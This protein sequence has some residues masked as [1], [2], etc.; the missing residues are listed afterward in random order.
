VADPEHPFPVP[1]A[2]AGRCP[3]VPPAPG[4]T[5]VSSLFA[6]EG[7]AG[8]D[9]AFAA[10][11]FVEFDWDGSA[12]GGLQT[13]GGFG[14][15]Q[16]VRSFATAP[17]TSCATATRTPTSAVF[18]GALAG[19]QFQLGLQAP[20]PLVRGVP[21]AD[22]TVVGAMAGDG[23]LS[24]RYQGDAFPSAGLR[25]LRDGVPQAT[26]TA[27]D[28]SCLAAGTLMGRRGAALAAWGRSRKVVSGTLTVPLSDVSSSDA[29]A[30]PL[31]SEHAWL[32]D[33][34]APSRLHVMV[35]PLVGGR[36]AG[37]RSLAA[38]VAQGLV[39]A[40]AG[41]GG[42]AIVTDPARPVA[43]RVRGRR[44]VLTTAQ[45]DAG[46]LHPLAT[47]G[48]RSAG[49]VAFA[50]GTLAVTARG[51]RAAAARAPDFTPPRTRARVRVRGSRAIVSLRA[52][53]RSGVAATLVALGGRRLT[54]HRGRV[55]VPRRRLGSVRFSSIDLFGN[56]EAPHRPG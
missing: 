43:V 13:G 40:A 30:S 27:V 29:A 55:S 21:P 45:L 8:Y 14:A 49:L 7:H 37:Y 23:T 17:P 6:G 5:P 39:A 19:N 36:P 24:L 12:I 44:A 31:C 20:N 9:G 16:R 4:A 50:G 25:V 48:P 28:A 11:P 33:A 18:G 26:R 54:L 22:A 35:A 42:V 34:A 32:L 15:V 56:V 41:S 3:G 38:A 52:H 2:F 53:D 46:A 51:G 10:Q 1:A 47:Y